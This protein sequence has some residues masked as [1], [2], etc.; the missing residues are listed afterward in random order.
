MSWL[1]S[2][3][4]KFIFIHI[5]KTGGTSIAEPDFKSG[6][7]A[8]I[9]QLGDDDHV[10]A[11]HIRAVGLRKCMLENWDEYFKFAFVR[12][13]WDRMVS[14]YHYFLQDPEKADSILGRQLAQFSD[15]NDF[16]NNLDGVELDS[17]FDGQ[18]SYLIDYEENMLVNYIGRFESIDKDLALICDKVGLSI[19]QLPHYRKSDHMSYRTYYDDASIEIVAKKYLSD[20]HAFKYHF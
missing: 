11:G 2:K 14:L 19:V 7:G 3:K 5:P 10:Q 9:G 17:H 18:I 1:V 6:Q 16:C 12:N 20:V 8:L 13:P 4:Y 15:F